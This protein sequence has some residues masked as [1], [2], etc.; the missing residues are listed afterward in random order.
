MTEHDSSMICLAIPLQLI[1]IKSRI[2]DL[3]L[4]EREIRALLSHS[5]FLSLSLRVRQIRF[6]DDHARRMLSQP[7]E[8]KELSTVFG[9]TTVVLWK[10]LQ[11][12]PVYP[13]SLIRH[14]ALG[15]DVESEIVTLLILSYRDGQATTQNTCH[16]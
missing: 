4:S 3:G 5:Y 14:Q 9:V 2:S 7:M 16:K 8:I 11:S 6:P 12:E 1:V 13:L 15:A 10:S